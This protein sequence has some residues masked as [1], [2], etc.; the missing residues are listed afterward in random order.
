MARKAQRHGALAFIF[1]RRDEPRNKR[2]WAITPEQA[3][4]LYKKKD[5]KSINWKWFHAN[6]FELKKLKSPIRWEVISLI[7]ANL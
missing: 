1:I 7:E 4:Y 3:D 6:A 2:V 5:G